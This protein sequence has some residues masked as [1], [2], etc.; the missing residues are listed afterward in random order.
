MGYV[1][2]CGM[3]EM[4]EDPIMHEHDITNGNMI[5]ELDGKGKD[6]IVFLVSRDPT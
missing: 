5:T 6:R 2:E 1:N 4:I 3:K